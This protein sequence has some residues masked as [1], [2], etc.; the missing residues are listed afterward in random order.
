MSAVNP[1]RPKRPPR[2]VITS[3]M[4]RLIRERAKEEHITIEAFAATMIA[5]FSDDADAV[6]LTLTAVAKIA[7]EEDRAG[8]GPLRTPFVI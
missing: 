6:Q 8:G 5:S 3:N 1:K 7:A 2:D 4:A